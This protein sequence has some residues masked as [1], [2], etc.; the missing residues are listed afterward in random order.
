MWCSRISAWLPAGPQSNG[1][2]AGKGGKEKREGD[3]GGLAVVSSSG[4]GG[5]GEG[6]VPT[7]MLKPPSSCLHCA[8][9]RSLLS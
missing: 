1:F 5:A 4:T 9:G 8:L 2:T 7:G 3:G 6:L